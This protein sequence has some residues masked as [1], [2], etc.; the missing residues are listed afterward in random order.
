MTCKW[1]LMLG[2]ICTSGS[3]YFPI[4]HLA[5]PHQLTLTVPPSAPQDRRKLR[6]GRGELPSHVELSSSPFF[7]L[8]ARAVPLWSRVP[9]CLARGCISLCFSG[10]NPLELGKSQH[11]IQLLPS[12]RILTA[13]WNC[14]TCQIHHTTHQNGK[15]GKKLN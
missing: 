11:S 10:W 14:G 12:F 8:A 7:L 1:I 6:S 5:A 3:H 9:F 13:Q 2:V 15:N 4:R